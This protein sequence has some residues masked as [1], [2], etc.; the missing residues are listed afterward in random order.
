MD[1]IWFRNR[2]YRGV[3][4]FAKSTDM[5]RE[6]GASR[7]RFSSLSFFLEIR[8]EMEPV[9]RDTMLP[10]GAR[11]ILLFLLLLLVLVIVLGLT[12][13]VALDRHGYATTEEGLYPNSC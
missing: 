5:T 6:S 4:R 9:I 1:D 2:L 11:A 8:Q 12:V 7:F 3:F 10:L 13:F